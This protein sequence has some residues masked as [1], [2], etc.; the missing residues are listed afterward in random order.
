M[1]TDST[2]I[3]KTESESASQ[4][5]RFGTLSGVFMPTLLTILGVI[6][7]LREGWVIGNSGLLGGLV[8]ITLAFGITTATGL[9]LS[10]LTTNIRIGAGGAYSVISQ[11]LG[12]EMGGSIGL[13]LYLS[14]V[15]AVAMYIFGFREGWLWVFPDHPALLVDLLLFGVLFG[16]AYVSAG[17][18]FKVQYVVAAVIAASLVS[19]GLAAATGSMQY[20]PQLW[21]SSSDDVG[22]ILLTEDFWAVFAVFFPAATGIMAGANMSGEL[23]D[24]RKS[25]PIGTMSA[26][27]VSY[28]IYMLLAY[29]LATSATPEELRSNYTIMIDKAFWGPAVL[30]GLLGA[31]FSSALSSI[32]GAPRIL[33]AL[34]EH[35]IIPGGKFLSKTSRE[36]EPRNAMIVSGALVVAALLLRD[37]NVVA[38]FITMFFLITYGMIN[39]VVLLEQSLGLVSFRP[40]LKLPTMIPLIG[41]LG[42]IF[43]MFIINPT[44]SL[45]AVVTVIGF[46]ALLI[47]R[48]LEAPFADV[49]SG[50][51]VAVAQWAAQKAADLP[52]TQE[53]AWKPNLLIPVSDTLELRGTHHF[54]E[55]LVWPTGYVEL[56]GM[57][58]HEPRDVLEPALRELAGDF[59]KEG[60]YTRWTVLDT[61]NVAEGMS[62][63]MEAL[64][65]AFFRPNIIFMP[66]PKSPAEEDDLT[67]IAAKASQSGLGMMVLG[68]HPKTRMGSK[69]V[70]NLW[71]HDRNPDM[72]LVLRESHI[73]LAILVAYMVTQNWKGRLN[74][75]SCVEED[76]T[77]E[78]VRQ[79]LQRV[80]DLA[81]LPDP[82]IHLLDGPFIDNLDK[83]PRADV[84]IMGLSRPPNFELMREAISKTRSTC[85]FVADSGKESA[86]A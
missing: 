49:R 63:G 16:I 30:G 47:R 20:E 15:L 64:Q 65:G 72:E 48:H 82:E 69:K 50:L 12:I 3:G 43:A 67:R 11:S 40:K 54:I 75:V 57:S 37:L 84:D 86:L 77:H 44:V 27:A 22:N 4:P 58:T 36:G 38:P 29:W 73:N 6:M 34:A 70:I 17:L 14:Q 41:A 56:M 28:V 78:E 45:I 74:L 2:T 59:R 71:V 62:L 19:V 81:R 18:A 33:Q 80:I 55:D 5:G 24:P 8:I 52:T 31:T 83:G 68:M 23:K 53:R 61:D 76:R 46:Y 35:S 9:S 66:M 1:K 25:I 26:I 32:V 79:E 21:V 60:I 7:F 51:F 10:S 39:A 42:C 13:P 85:V